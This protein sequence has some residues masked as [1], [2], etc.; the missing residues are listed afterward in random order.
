MSVIKDARIT[1]GCQCGAVRYRLESVPD[2]A[3]ICHCRMCQ[4]ASGGAFTAFCGV[5]KTDLV[6]TS[7]AVS[8]FRSSD[9]AERGFCALCGTPLTYHVLGSQR[10]GVTIG[11]LDD[12]NSVVPGEQLGT[13]SRVRWLSAALNAPLASLDDWLESRGVSSVGSRQHPD[14]ES[15]ADA[16]ARVKPASS[17]SVRT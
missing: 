6:V 3:V 1:G 11:S 14:G 10:I 4:K 7:G 17:T 15:A 8:V 16:G 9:I 2:G 13:E 12:P 5:P